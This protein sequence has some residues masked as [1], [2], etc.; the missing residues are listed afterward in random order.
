MASQSATSPTRLRYRLTI[1]SNLHPLLYTKL[2]LLEK[3]K[4]GISVLH[5]AN[6]AA[7]PNMDTEALLVNAILAVNSECHGSGLTIAI[8][9]TVQS[10]EFTK[11]LSLLGSCP[12]SVRPDVVVGLANLAVSQYSAAEKVSS[13]TQSPAI[14]A[15]PPQREVGL[16]E[17]E[18]ARERP[19]ETPEV[20]PAQNF[21]VNIRR[22]VQASTDDLK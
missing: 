5:L 18:P 13:E 15:L 17:S 6:L 14:T 16:Q 9:K 7:E 2:R 3:K 10:G 12:K 19:V 4:R 8:D 21:K 20:K 1:E 11:L 22:A